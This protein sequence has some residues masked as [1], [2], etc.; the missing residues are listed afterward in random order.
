M[1]KWTENRASLRKE[2]FE[3]EE[4]VEYTFSDYMIEKEE[5]CK[6]LITFFDNKEKIFDE[7]MSIFYQNG[8]FDIFSF[9]DYYS[10]LTSVYYFEINNLEF[11]LENKV[12]LVDFLRNYFNKLFEINKKRSSNN[13]ESLKDKF[14]KL[15]N[16]LNIVDKEKQLDIMK[17][18][19]SSLNHKE[20]Y[21]TLF[22]I[23]EVICHYSEAKTEKSL[24]TNREKLIEIFSTAYLPI[25]KD[26][27]Y[28]I[29]N[30]YRKLP[31]DNKTR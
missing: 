2:L 5:W 24:Y 22:D 30:Y 20:Q 15:I 28:S 27:F 18:Y 10:Y 7:Y 4:N 11:T 6:N 17:T 12:K 8:E 14:I 21:C 31:E 19:K 13:S 25:T 1:N 23:V 26:L 29:T 3:N 9:F 16:D